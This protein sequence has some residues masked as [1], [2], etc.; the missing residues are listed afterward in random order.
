MPFDKVVYARLVSISTTFNI[1]PCDNFTIWHRFNLY[2][3]YQPQKLLK[4]YIDKT[5]KINKLMM[6][7]D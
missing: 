4:L 5:I 2:N 6:K 7:E 1:V 3:L